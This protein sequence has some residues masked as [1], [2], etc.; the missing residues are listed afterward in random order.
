MLNTFRICIFCNAVVSCTNVVVDVC[1]STYFILLEFVYFVIQS[2]LVQM[3]GLL[4]IVQYISYGWN[5][6]F[7]F[8]VCLLF[9][10]ILWKCCG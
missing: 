7:C 2:Y 4:F 3:L 9:S 6:F 10:R 5:S 1:G 8:F